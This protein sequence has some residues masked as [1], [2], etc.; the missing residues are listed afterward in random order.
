MSSSSP[1]R[2]LLDRF[3]E[4]LIAYR[5][6]DDN[7]NRNI[8][9]HLQEDRSNYKDLDISTYIYSYLNR[10]ALPLSLHPDHMETEEDPGQQDDP[11]DDEY[12][13]KEHHEVDSTPSDDDEVQEILPP[14]LA[15][16]H[17]EKQEELDL[18]NEF[19]DKLVV[20]WLSPRSDLL[21]D[22]RR[23]RQYRTGN[24]ESFFN[25]F[26]DACC[27]DQ[28]KQYRDQINPFIIRRKKEEEL[29]MSTLFYKNLEG[30]YRFINN[31]KP[32]DQI[33]LDVNQK[34]NQH[35]YKDLDLDHFMTQY[36]LDCVSGHP[37]TTLNPYEAKRQQT[38]P[39]VTER[40]R[41]MMN[42]FINN[43]LRE[44][45]SSNFNEREHRTL[46]DDIITKRHTEPNVDLE[47]WMMNYLHSKYP[48]CHSFNKYNR[49]IPFYQERQIQQANQRLVM[50]GDQ[51]RQNTEQV[52]MNRFISNMLTHTSP[53]N[54]RLKN[55]IIGSRR[56]DPH[57]NLET[58][59]KMYLNDKGY[60]PGMNQRVN[61]FILDRQPS[62]RIV[63]DMSSPPSVSNSDQ[64][65]QMGGVL[66]QQPR[67]HSSISMLET[68]LS[69]PI[70]YHYGVGM[71]NISFR[72]STNPPSASSNSSKPTPA[73]GTIICPPMDD[74]T[75]DNPKY[76]CGV[77]LCNEI[78]VT[79]VPC[80]HTYC[81]SCMKKCIDINHKGTDKLPCP[82]CR[83]PIDSVVQL[84][85]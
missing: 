69:H 68:V 41:I 55:N 33:R 42:K 49:V 78:K 3:Y 16:S 60:D 71:T 30:Y 12:D 66:V 72:V 11:E 75:T 6:A 14:L 8:W 17:D 28:I 79:L 76:Q 74:S 56:N 63:D 67:T 61:P 27:L 54:T 21:N 47:T 10:C 7:H 53:N 50:D 46:K 26:I 40:E 64:F 19:V 43:V 15:S 57:I 32:L 4:K 44:F 51:T 58:W 37:R 73:S 18:I 59:I 84:R 36:L 77:C 65:R 81:Y 23:Q 20:H 22:V 39:Q 13:P 34:R 24:L 83:S 62:Q 25:Y 1:Q 5:I 70:N 35:N 2:Y 85:I 48:N 31:P 38:Q 29:Q 52:M 80:G 82:Q 9:S 45:T